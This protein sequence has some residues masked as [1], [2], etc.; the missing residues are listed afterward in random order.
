MPLL[1]NEEVELPW[2]LECDPPKDDQTTMNFTLGFC[3]K[4]RHQS[5]LSLP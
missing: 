5:T 3:K 2:F 4:F 1:T